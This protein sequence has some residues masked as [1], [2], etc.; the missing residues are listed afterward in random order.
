MR[1][2]LDCIPCFYVQALKAARISGVSEEIQREVLNHLSEL[3]PKFSLN[4]TPAEMGKEI[5]AIISKV[6][7]KKDPYRE[8]KEESNKMALKLYPGLKIKVK[9]SENQLLTAIK[10]SIIG[11]MIDYGMKDFMEIDE[12]VNKMLDD[13]F[14]SLISDND[15]HFDY[16]GFYEHLLKIETILYLADNAG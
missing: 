8:I 6:T 2:F 7:G 11:N 10:L 5:Y 16:Y 9:S 12:E 15:R 14:D 3:I 13:N 4:I 1:T